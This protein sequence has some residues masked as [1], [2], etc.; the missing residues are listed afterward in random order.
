MFREYILKVGGGGGSG[1]TCMYAR[2]E[3]TAASVKMS[4]LQVVAPCGQATFNS[5][6]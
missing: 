6:S 4:A 5:V 2:S 3:L 1:I